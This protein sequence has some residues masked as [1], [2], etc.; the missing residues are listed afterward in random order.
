MHDNPLV[1]GALMVDDLIEKA[2]ASPRQRI[3]LSFHGA[4]PGHAR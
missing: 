2:K 3:A 4:I 1:I